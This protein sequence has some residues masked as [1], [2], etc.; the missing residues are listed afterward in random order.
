VSPTFYR[1]LLGSPALQPA[2][3]HALVEAARAIKRQAVAL[4]HR[5]RGKNIALLCALPDSASARR[6]DAAASAL[7]ARVARID[8]A[9]PWLDEQSDLGAETARL[10][11]NL[12]DAVDCEELPPG[13]ARRLQAQ[14]GVP[15]YDGLAR[16]DHP[17]FRLLPQVAG[18]GHT[19]DDADRRALLQATLV[20]T[21]L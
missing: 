11:E 6:F 12:Y 14:L 2:D 1:R 19:P 18:C 13:V 20:N 16:D 8:P 21:L 5:L 4:P 15:V 9:P 10:L 7:G 17:I 3:A